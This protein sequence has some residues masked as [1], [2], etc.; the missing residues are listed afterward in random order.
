MVTR[1]ASF[2]NSNIPHDIL[3]MQHRVFDKF[4]I[5]HEQHLT[6]QPHSHAIDDFILAN[7]FDLLMLFDIDCIPLDGRIIGDAARIVTERPCI[8]GAIQ[9]ANHIPGSP[10]YVSPAFMC[11]TQY[12]YEL[13]GRPSFRETYRSDVGG[14]ITHR[15]RENSID[16]EFLKV[17]SVRTPQW[18]LSDGTPFGHGT[19][20]G[21]RVFH[22]FKSR[23]GGETRG[24]FID[25]CR[26]ILAL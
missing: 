6:D 17:A 24:L 4:G 15:A 19:N 20:Y 18:R 9:N 1:I 8:Y 10:D 23:H 3:D 26:E 22:A 14:E 7:D 13:I 25:K 5:H 2:Y 11:L 16:V 21:N 12:T